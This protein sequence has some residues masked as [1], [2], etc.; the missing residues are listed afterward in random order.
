MTVIQG[1]LDSGTTAPAPPITCWL[2]TEQPTGV[3]VVIFP[4]GGYGMLAAHEGEGYARFLSENGVAAFVV[5]YRLG[6]AGHRHPAML[7]DALSAVAAVRARASEFGL[8]ADKIGVMGSSAGGHLTAHALVGWP[9][10]E[11]AVSCRPDFGILCYPVILSTGP[12][13]HKGSMRNLAGED[14]SDEL[15]ATLSCDR[16]VNSQTPPCFLWHTGEDAAV[17]LENSLAF[18][19]ALRRC[20]VPFELHL[21]NKGRHGLGLDTPFEWARDC[22]RWIAETV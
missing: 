8:D 21:Y 7:E 22:L 19:A 2:P 10:Y 16:H 6:S 14:V 9:L 1:C 20:D 11:N 5:Q 17:P 12:F 18:A 3:G 15:L 13:A 4:G